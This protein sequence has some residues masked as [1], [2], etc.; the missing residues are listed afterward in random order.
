MISNKSV[1]IC[2]RFHTI[3]ANN[4]K[5]TFL[6]GYPSLMLSF[7]RNPLTQGHKIL[8]RKT[9]DLEAAHGEDFVIL[10]CIFMIQITSVTDRQTDA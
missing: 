5:I 3:Q 10:A 4:G 6:G 8:S 7:E 9:R 1:P 2:N